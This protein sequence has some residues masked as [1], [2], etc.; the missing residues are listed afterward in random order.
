L[1]NEIKP[2]TLPKQEWRQKEAPQRSTAEPATDGQT[3]TPGGQTAPSG[4]QTTQAHKAHSL[5]EDEAGPTT[6]PSSPHTKAG[7]QT[8]GLGGPTASSY[9]V[10][11]SSSANGISSPANMEEDTNDDLLDYK[12]SHARDGME[13]N[14]IYLSTIDYSLLE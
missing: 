14:V 1:F 8:T 3:V 13:I 6:A 11:A 7:G 10:D 12:P 4:G 2:M 5:T 9:R